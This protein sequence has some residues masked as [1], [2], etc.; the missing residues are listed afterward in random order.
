[1][2][3]IPT[4]P[5]GSVIELDRAHIDTVRADFVKNEV[6]ITISV[7]L[8]KALLEKREQLAFLAWDEATIVSVSI[9]PLQEKLL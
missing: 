5:K 3:H 1:M 2:A 4:T 9:Q 8:D 6:K 7:H